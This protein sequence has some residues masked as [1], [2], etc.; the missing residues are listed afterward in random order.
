MLLCWRLGREE[1]VR[2][3]RQAL[4][5]LCGPSAS[6][7]EVSSAM[8]G[9]VLGGVVGLIPL[10][11]GFT[12]RQTALGLVGL[13]FCAFAGFLTGL[14]GP[15]VVSIGFVIGIIASWHRSRSQT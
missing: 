14:L 2:P 4:G 13:L 7:L 5:L 11:L 3:R 6:P 15:I 8:R 9:L 12:L 10:L 1:I